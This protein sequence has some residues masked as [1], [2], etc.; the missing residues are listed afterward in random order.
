MKNNLKSTG[1]IL[2]GVALFLISS[3]IGFFVANDKMSKDKEI[4]NKQEEV[5]NGPKAYTVSLTDPENFS[6]VTE[7]YND[8]NNLNLI[9]TS[10]SIYS[11]LVADIWAY[12]STGKL[13]NEFSHN[14]NFVGNGDSILI[15]LSVDAD[16]VDSI[17]VDVSN[18]KQDEELIVYDRKLLDFSTDVNDSNLE[19]VSENKLNSDL[20]S[21]KGY[22][23]FYK[24]DTLVD[25]LPFNIENVS[26]ENNI[27]TSIANTTKEYD[28]VKVHINE[29]L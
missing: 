11:Y 23:T 1:L 3:S 14:F 18:V 4:E 17:V 27:S 13:S 7:S 20:L 10:K 6:V 15:N 9:I 21:V 24:G 29:I 22:I 2:C 28:K 19:I 12:D 26:K 16:I 25:T 8:D 5:T